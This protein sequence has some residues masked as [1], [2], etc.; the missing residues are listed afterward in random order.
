MLYASAPDQNDIS[1]HATSLLHYLTAH[2]STIRI[3][4]I[5]SFSNMDPINYNNAIY[6]LLL[7]YFQFSF[8]LLIRGQ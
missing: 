7:L 3:Y 4:S 1:C 5:S 8:K 6:F 2:P